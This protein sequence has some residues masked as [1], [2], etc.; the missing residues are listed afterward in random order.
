MTD[1]NHD[2][3]T[4][5]RR[6]RDSLTERWYVPTEVEILRLGRAADKAEITY[7]RQIA[8]A[9]QEVAVDRL[10]PPPCDDPA[11][12]CGRSVAP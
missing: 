6:L 12:P 4:M 8:R 2:A 9:Y 1:E 7:L 11:C 3:V 10:D 5:L